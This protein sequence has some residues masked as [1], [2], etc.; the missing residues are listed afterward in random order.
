MLTEKDR[1]VILSPYSF[2]PTLRKSA[3]FRS[4]KKI[5]ELLEDLQ[6]LIENDKKIQKEFG[7]D[8]YQG[9]EIHKPSKPEKRDNVRKN[10]SNLL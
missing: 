3:R 5:L 9:I 1:R 4:K 7:I 10:S 8:M 6:F 2:S